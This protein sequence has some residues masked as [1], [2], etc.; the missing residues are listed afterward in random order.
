MNYIILNDEEYYQDIKLDRFKEVSKDGNRRVD[1]IFG[2]ITKEILGEEPSGSGEGDIFPGTEWLCRD[3]G[4]RF[5]VIRVPQDIL[6]DNTGESLER[7][8]RL[9][10]PKS[11]WV[12]LGSVR[13]K[14]QNRYEY[15]F[16][17]YNKNS[18]DFKIIFD[19]K[20]EEKEE[21][22]VLDYILEKVKKIL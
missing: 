19:E 15:F 4:V 8:F 5:M 9:F 21:S 10:D 6:Y 20:A 3:S 11:F 14:D 1:G 2:T 13:I 7:C 22:E 16:I 18:I 12:E 17:A